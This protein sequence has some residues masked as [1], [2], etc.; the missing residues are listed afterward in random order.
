M[1]PHFLFYNCRQGSAAT[2]NQEMENFKFYFLSAVF[3]IVAMQSCTVNEDAGFDISFPCNASDSILCNAGQTLSI[4]YTLVN[5]GDNAVV[6]C[7]ADNGWAAEVSSETNTSGKIA[8]T[9]PDPFVEGQ[10][11]VFAYR[12][13]GKTVMKTLSFYEQI[14]EFSSDEY[15][16]PHTGGPV[17]LELTANVPEYEITVDEAGSSWLSIDEKTK[18]AVNTKNIYLTAKENPGVDDRSATVSV[19]YGNLTVTTSVLQTASPDAV[20]K[21]SDELVLSTLLKETNVDT[22]GNGLITRKEAASLTSI[23]NIFKG[24]PITSFEEFQYFTSITSLIGREFY[25][26]SELKSIILPESITEIRGFSG[27]T[28]QGCEKLEYIKL[29]SSLESITQASPFDQCYS[30]TS[31]Y[32][33]DNVSVFNSTSF[34]DLYSLES[35]HLP[36]DATVEYYPLFENCH[37]LT[38]SDSIVNLASVVL[39]GRGIAFHNCDGLREIS[40]PDGADA[41]W[42][43]EDCDNLRRIR[44]GQ[45]KDSVFHPTKFD[46]NAPVTIYCYNPVPVNLPLGCWCD[47]SDYELILKQSDYCDRYNLT[48]IWWN[49][50]CPTE[51]LDFAFVDPF[52]SY[53]DEDQFLG[54]SSGQIYRNKMITA[55]YVPA[56]SVD[57]YKEKWAWYKD[58]IHPLFEN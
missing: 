7:T 10:I 15:T 14:L 50:E 11:Q 57:L 36:K 56:E 51:T 16:V 31:L 53:C 32:I 18:T 22:D 4:E 38:S 28:F 58:I 2:N 46:L 37:A 5:A 27:G 19:T 49:W 55:I 45:V 26:C 23:I 12:N 8:V 13:D 24:L 34:I 43:I 1:T 52:N 17:I 44:I 20:I 21:F 33:P 42:Y 3:I 29:P 47:R 6:K 35:I 25:M 41:P 9:V 30:L 54:N 40:L 39:Q 48:N